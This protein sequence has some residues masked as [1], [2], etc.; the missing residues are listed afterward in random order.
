MNTTKNYHKTEQYIESLTNLPKNNWMEVKDKT[1]LLNR[2]KKL[3]EYLGNPQN[4]YE[5]I[6]VGGTAGKGSTSH[7]I[8]YFLSQNNIKTGLYTSPHITTTIERIQI[9]N[10]FIS[11]QQYT[12]LI[13]NKIKPAIERIHE[14]TQDMPSYFEIQLAIALMYF[15]SQ[16]CKYVVLEVGCGG[17]FDGTNVVNSSISVITNIGLDHTHILGNTKEKI[18]YEKAGII[19]QNIPIFTTESNPKILNIIESEAIKKNSPFIKVKTDN[20]QIIKHYP[21]LIFK[22]Y[23]QE[24]Q[25]SLLGEKQISNIILAKAVIEHLNFSTNFSINI[26]L[27]CRLE[28]MQQNPTIILDG[29]HNELKIKN[30]LTFIKNIPH[31]KISCIFG[32]AEDKNF[33]DIL[34]PLLKQVDEIIFTKFTNTDRKAMSPTILQEYTQ[35]YFKSSI[36]STNPTNALKNILSNSK[37]EDIIIVVGSFYLA[38]EIREQWVSKKHVL[39]TRQIN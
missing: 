3:L 13:N 39:E 19:K 29:A 18:A 34:K 28:I 1:I 32:I 14:E 2:Q 12:D 4:N 10:L 5:I 27:P 11:P 8:R 31:K 9:N 21:K 38:G 22:H 16:Q 17:R 37:S 24:I 35:R 15:Q 20:A 26:H 36:I 33:E 23:D 30:L 25:S 7:I 6:H